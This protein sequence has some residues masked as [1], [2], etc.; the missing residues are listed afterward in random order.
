HRNEAACDNKKAAMRNNF[1]G[2]SKMERTSILL[3]HE[4]SPVLESLCTELRKESFQPYRAHSCREA[5]HL[6]E[7]TDPHIVFTDVH[8]PDGSWVDVLRSVDHA[9]ACANVIV[10]SPSADMKFYIRAIEQGAF[11]FVV[12][13]FETRSLTHVIRS[14]ILNSAVRRHQRL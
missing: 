8:L 6:I 5:R 3:V 10:V 11:D 2:G 7:E 9:E 4:A 1:G 14:A 12:P 13:P